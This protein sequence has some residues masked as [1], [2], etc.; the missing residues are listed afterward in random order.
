MDCSESLCGFLSCPGFIY[1]QETYYKWNNII[2]QAAVLLTL[3]HELARILRRKL[4]D[5]KFY[6][7]T[8]EINLNGIKTI[9]EASDAFVFFP[10]KVCV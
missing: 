6:S 2:G 10:R 4:I 5:E 1:I 9:C 3:L 7:T 8:G